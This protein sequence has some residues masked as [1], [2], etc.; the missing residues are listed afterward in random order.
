MFVFIQYKLAEFLSKQIFHSVVFQ[1][2]GYLVAEF[3]ELFF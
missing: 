3:A 1:I 2:L